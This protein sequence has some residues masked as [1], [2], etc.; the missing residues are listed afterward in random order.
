MDRGLIGYPVNCGGLLVSGGNM[1]N[2]V[3]F[4]AARTAKAGW[5][6]RKDGVSKI[7]DAG[8]ARIVRAKRTR[9]F[10]RP[11]TLAASAPNRSGG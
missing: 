9:G 4:L 3:C 6:V 11:Q 2:F 8:F 7:R 5:D 1:A 10:K